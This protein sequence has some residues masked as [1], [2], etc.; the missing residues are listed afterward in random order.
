MIVWLIILGMIGAFVFL[1][2]WTVR[3]EDQSDEAIADT[4]DWLA[5]EAI[6]QSAVMERLDKYTRYPSF[7][8]YY[9]VKG[10]F[11]SGKFF[12]KIVMDEAEEQIKALVG[13]KFEVQYDP[14]S[15]SAWYIAEATM[16]GYAIIQKL[17]ADYPSDYGPYRSDGDEPIDLNLNR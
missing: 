9:S 17:D 6:I 7:S 8:F 4:A 13:H 12:Q 10:E 5:T 11:Y 14:D 1:V 15:P 16:A 3:K 2:V